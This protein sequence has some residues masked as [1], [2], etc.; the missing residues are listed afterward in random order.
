VKS[1]QPKPQPVQ[2]DTLAE[3]LLAALRT[4]GFNLDAPVVFMGDA[5]AISAKD[6]IFQIAEIAAEYKAS[7][8]DMIK[9]VPDM[10]NLLWDFT[11]EATDKYGDLDLIKLYIA[12]KV[13]FQV[14]ATK[15]A[16]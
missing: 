13:Y 14:T 8:P 1:V 11:G 2:K 12:G 9:L 7:I 3:P 5:T 16:L 15:P 4:G 10:Y 6:V